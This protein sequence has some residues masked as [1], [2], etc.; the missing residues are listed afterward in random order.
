[1]DTPDPTI[2]VLL[3]SRAIESPGVEGGFQLLA[4]LAKWFDKSDQVSPVTFCAARRS[5]DAGALRAFRRPGW[6]RAR[7][8]EFAL[9]LARYAG[10]F[11]IVHTA[12]VPTRDNSR[13]MRGL[14]T[15]PRARGT[16]FVQTVTAL[17]NVGDDELRELLWGD[18]VV[19][20]SE[21]ALSRVQALGIE[22]TLIQPWPSP[23]RLA[24]T[25]SR[26]GMVR[27]ALS[28]TS[29]PLVVFPGEFDRLGVGLDL[30]P[31]IDELIARTPDVLVVLACRNDRTGIG[32]HLAEV[33]PGHIV[34]VGQV[35]WILD[36]L[37]AA[38]V[39][40]FP[41]ATMHGKFQPPLV[42]MEALQLGTPVVAAEPVERISGVEGFAQA[43]WPE[44]GGPS[45]F[46]DLIHRSL[47]A[48]EGRRQ[49]TVEELLTG[50]FALS[51]EQYSRVYR[52]VFRAAPGR[53]EPGARA[54]L[55]HRIGRDLRGDGNWAFQGS[56][57]SRRD[58]MT[59]TRLKDLDVW[60]S[61]DYRAR[62]EV[63]LEEMHA[64]PIAATRD[65]SWLQHSAYALPVAASTELVDLTVGDL[66]VGPFLLCPEERI[67]TGKAADGPV[68]L[69]WAAIADNLLRPV[70]RGRVPEA[71]RV[72][73][74]RV[75]WEAMSSQ[76]RQEF[77]G[78]VTTVLGRT[79]S[80]WVLETLEASE[81]ATVRARF[82]RSMALP[83]L[84]VRPKQLRS[85]WLHR[86][87]VYSGGAT[88]RP[89][90]KRIAGL[91]VVL[92]GTD[93]AGKTATSD[94]VARRLWRVNVRAS[95]S[96]FGRSRGNLPGVSYLREHFERRSQR[97][98]ESSGLKGR[99]GA[100]PVKVRQ[101]AAWYYS[102]EY[103][104]RAWIGVM[105]RVWAGKV[106]LLDRY[107]YD[108]RV[109]GTASVGPAKLAERLAP[110]PHVVV[111]L[112]ADPEVLHDRKPERTTKEFARQRAV[113]SR[114]AQVAP[115]RLA[116][117]SVRSDRTPLQELVAAIAKELVT[118]THRHH[119]TGATKV[120]KELKVRE[121]LGR[122]G[123][124]SEM[125][126]I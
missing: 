97:A 55:L 118:L 45:R 34:N 51:A 40:I 5:G 102:I 9:A 69:G 52:Q 3:A 7:Q 96:Y 85:L 121:S 2:P 87:A 14:A 43:P 92:I 36:L 58:W 88:R 116:T 78:H 65:R 19:C 29:R 111:H 76:L 101:L 81:A 74:A 72:A 75:A 18:H 22:A 39:V 113:Y 37:K 31:M 106:V 27:T 61:T 4:D 41:A 20:Q 1:M 105:P 25:Y 26:A 64:V 119:I 57:A 126:P 100:T 80:K 77:A 86:V 112:D 70:L 60:S 125:G 108:L 120:S 59:T 47:G 95:R 104:L 44:G 46:A 103:A 12:H 16:R 98:G 83:R 66:F 68:F 99:S 79:F 8:V 123:T 15:R 82:L 17:P 109:M 90:G 33:R 115:A 32:V 117:W 107:V 50:Q 23:D 67:R 10:R 38:D 53:A 28:A 48:S 21:R 42:L 122:R 84:I 63:A 11:P 94:R 91:L 13:V 6:N 124:S 71:E 114:V 110:R 62:A 54:E 24:S 93:G 73:A 89:F 35:T 49:R 56:T 30:L